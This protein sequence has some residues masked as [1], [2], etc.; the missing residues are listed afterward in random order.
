[1]ALLEG[2]QDTLLVGNPSL[3][4]PYPPPTLGIEEPSIE[5]ILQALTMA[6]FNENS[7]SEQEFTQGYM[8]EFLEIQPQLRRSPFN[9]SISTGN[10]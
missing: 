7:L 1:M 4:F 9:R 5:V 3:S 10:S 8:E 6:E 2:S